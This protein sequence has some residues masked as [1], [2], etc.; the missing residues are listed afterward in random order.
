[1]VVLELN[2]VQE[3]VRVPLVSVEDD[4]DVVTFTVDVCA[5]VRTAEPRF[6]SR[7]KSSANFGD[8]YLFLIVGGMVPEVALQLTQSIV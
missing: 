7:R 6:L 5:G 2:I 1:M 4:R 3:E 8:G